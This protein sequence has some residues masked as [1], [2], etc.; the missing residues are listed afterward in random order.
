MGGARRRTYATDGGIWYGYQEKDKN[1]DKIGQ[2]RA[3]KWKEREKTRPTMP[4][5][6]IGQEQPVTRYNAGT[7]PKLEPESQP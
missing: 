4:S 7:K 6:F 3:R 1:K 5:L 2:N